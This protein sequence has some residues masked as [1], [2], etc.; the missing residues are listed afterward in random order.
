LKGYNDFENK[1]KQ[2]DIQFKKVEIPEGLQEQVA[3]E[4]EMEVENIPAKIKQR[5]TMKGFLDSFKNGLIDMFK[6]EEDA[7]L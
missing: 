5:K 3:V 2:F 4:E 1:R 6:E 7:K